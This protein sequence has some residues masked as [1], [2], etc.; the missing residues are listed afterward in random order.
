MTQEA[1]LEPAPSEEPALDGAQELLSEQLAERLRTL[2]VTDELRPGTPL[3]ERTLAEQLQVSRTPLRDALKILASDGLVRLLPNRGAVVAEL[4]PEQIEE[5]LDVL[6]VIEEF[7]AIR[8]C[9]L[10]TDAEIGEI[11]ALHH[12]MLAAYER[13]DRMAYFQLN[14]RIHRGIVT[15]A[16]NQTLSDVHGQLNRQLYRYR[17]QGSVT[18]EIW[19]TAVD[20]HEVIV[21]LLSGRDAEKLGSYLRRHVHRTWEQ[22]VVAP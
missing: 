16:R 20:E 6:G 19:H 11:R 8:A 9:K 22:L 1:R 10:A 12:E 3:R 14:Q 2:I 15:A 13:R 17:Y 7:A 21:E 5:K 4:T 18:S